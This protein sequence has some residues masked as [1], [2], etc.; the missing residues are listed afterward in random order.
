MTMTTN[1]MMLLMYLA[2]VLIHLPV[3]RSALGIDWFHNG[4]KS[5]LLGAGPGDTRLWDIATGQALGPALRDTAT[6]NA[7]AFSPSGT[8]LATG[9]IDKKAV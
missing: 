3:R 4:N 8:S 2:L 7:L 6:V 1:T 9:G 5:V